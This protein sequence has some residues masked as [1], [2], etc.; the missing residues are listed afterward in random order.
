MK[1]AP[2]ELAQPDTL[3]QALQLRSD[4][5][6]FS[7]ALAGGQSLMP[8]LNLRLSRPE[9]VID[10]NRLDELSQLRV[11]GDRLIVGAMTRHA[12]LED[13]PQVGARIPA[14]SRMAS[15]IGHRAIRHRGTIGGSLCHADPS[16]ELSALATAM[17]AELVVRSVNGGRTI[18]ESDFNLGYLSTALEPDEL[19]TEIRWPLT[20]HRTAFGSAQFLR[21]S[22]DFA[23]AAVLA[24]LE[25]GP[26]GDVATARVVAYGS[27]PRPIRLTEV[28]QALV[29]DPRTADVSALAEIGAA[30]LEFGA[31]IH[32]SADYKRQLFTVMG[33]R[34]LTQAIKDWERGHQ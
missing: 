14:L 19:L 16:A 25:C 13:D 4:D 27:V 30:T 32:G 18:M 24:L 6:I 20:P 21:R 2:F 8:L 5:S 33:R 15:L 31:D 1:P 11:D 3:E 29:G 10:L 7:V 22:G 12:T 23:V 26:D 17:D 9:L 34:A 28:E